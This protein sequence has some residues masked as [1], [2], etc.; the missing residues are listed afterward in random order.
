MKLTD[1]LR[2]RA[3]GEEELASALELDLGADIDG[4]G[5]ESLPTAEI[6]PNPYQPR[7]RIQPTELAE[8]A[9]SI[10]E[11]GLLH[12]IVVRPVPHGYQLVAGE[13]RLR[14]CQ[15]LGWERIPAIVRE[16]DD[17]TT[18]ELALIENIQRKD[19][20]VFEEAEGYR[21][22]IEEFG[23]TQEELAR[24]IGCAQS[25]IANR[26]RLLRLPPEIQEIISREMISERHARALLRLP[27][28]EMQMAVLERIIGEGLSVKA[29]ERMVKTILEG[30]KRPRGKQSWV[31]IIKDTRPFLNSLH[32]LTE[33]LKRTGLAVDVRQR[34]EGEDE[35]VIEIHI[36][37]AKK[38]QTEG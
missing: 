20:D 16:M 38:G 30:E 2:A 29:T 8:L 15:T 1:I 9:A 7:R 32:K 19:L 24:R 12:P 33:G 31:G 11:H 35:L 6:E 25:T 34:S 14:A 21:R 17:Q 23:F 18:A 3:K 28:G 10:E 36:A 27:D 37:K 13:R 5:V 4:E 26:L 22:L